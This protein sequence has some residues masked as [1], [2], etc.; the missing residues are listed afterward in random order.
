[1]YLGITT[2]RLSVTMTTTYGYQHTSLKHSTKYG[3]QSIYGPLHLLYESWHSDNGS[4]QTGHESLQDSGY[5]FLQDPG[6]GTL[7]DSEYGFL[8][9][10]SYESLQNSGYE[11]QNSGYEAL[12]NSDSLQ[13]S[14]FGS[15]QNS[16]EYPYAAHLSVA[17][18]MSVLGVFAISTN[19]FVM[20]IFLR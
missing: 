16:M 12:Q 1:M 2:L 15:L 4:W 11:L 10:S 14:E 9:N 8:Q 3:H 17:I 6:Y 20:Y 5:G 13:N 18:A 7:Q 19:C